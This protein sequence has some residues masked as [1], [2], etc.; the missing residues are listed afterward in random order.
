MLKCIEVKLLSP[1][2]QKGK[3]GKSATTAKRKENQ[4]QQTRHC[5]HTKACMH[6]E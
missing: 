6:V 5:T 2:H 4:Q 3:E 1:T